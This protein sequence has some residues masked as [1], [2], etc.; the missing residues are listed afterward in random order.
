MDAGSESKNWWENNL[1]WTLGG[2]VQETLEA[3]QRMLGAIPTV[4]A[5]A[6]GSKPAEE[7]AAVRPLA[8]TSKMT[9]P[10]PKPACLEKKPT[11]TQRLSN[12][13]RLSSSQRMK[14]LVAPS[15]LSNVLADVPPPLPA[16]PPPLPVSPPPLPA[17]PPP[18]PV[19][20]APVVD[21]KSTV[22]TQKFTLSQLLDP[23]FCGYS[24]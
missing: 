9:M 19:A 6:V 1:E 23:D 12:S 18:L 22:E 5:A 24:Q 15:S 11:S 7:Q 13:Q 21:D 2:S 8:R 17:V 20:K 16:V 4:L 10:P 3:G 14:A